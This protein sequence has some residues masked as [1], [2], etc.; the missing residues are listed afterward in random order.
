MQQNVYNRIRQLL[1]I[2]VMQGATGLHLLGPSTFGYI[3]TG[4]S[5]SDSIHNI[6]ELSNVTIRNL[7]HKV[8]EVF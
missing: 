1:A 3:F 7:A 4:I 5:G 6:E 2:V 8:F